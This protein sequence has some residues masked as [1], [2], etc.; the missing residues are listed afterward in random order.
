M[1]R[2]QLI[3]LL[4]AEHRGHIVKLT[5]D[6]ALCEFQLSVVAAAGRKLLKPRCLVVSIFL[7]VYPAK[8]K[9]LVNGFIIGNAFLA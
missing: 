9:R 3:E 7:A 1:L 8:A 4:I 5:G 2:R 6:G